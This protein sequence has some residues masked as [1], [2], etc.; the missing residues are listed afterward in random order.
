MNSDIIYV[1]NF[2]IF[3]LGMDFKKTCMT[4]LST[5][6]TPPSGDACTYR[7][8]HNGVD[9]HD[10][11][12][13]D[14]T[15]P[16]MEFMRIIPDILSRNERPP[17]ENE[18]SDDGSYTETGTGIYGND[19]ISCDGSD[20]SE[21][22]SYEDT[23]EAAIQNMDGTFCVPEKQSF[24]IRRMKN[25][26][27]AAQLARAQ[28]RISSSGGSGKSVMRNSFVRS[29]KVYRSQRSAYSSASSASYRPSRLTRRQSVV[30]R[31]SRPTPRTRYNQRNVESVMQ[32]QEQNTKSTSVYNL[33]T[34]AP[35][36]QS[37]ESN[38]NLHH[39]TDIKLVSKSSGY[40]SQ[41]RSP[42]GGVTSPD[43]VDLDNSAAMFQNC[44]FMC[45]FKK[46]K[47]AARVAKTVP[48]HQPAT[49]V[50]MNREAILRKSALL[51][52]T[53][54]RDIEAYLRNQRAT[55]WR[56]ADIYPSDAEW[57]AST[58]FTSDSNISWDPS[59]VSR[60]QRKHHHRNG[61]LEESRVS[62][63]KWDN[64]GLHS[65]TSDVSLNFKRRFRYNSII[66]LTST[67]MV[68]K[69]QGYNV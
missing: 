24:L 11:T 67:P 57:D 61:N 48:H 10:N 62:S 59:L 1:L 47:A 35:V 45:A 55:F 9:H 16:G 42:P 22:E 51:S 17:S 20:V 37:P 26:K 65:Q 14:S 25:A 68:A 54:I 44:N 12:W 8:Y 27:Q 23:T 2:S 18:T 6:Q 43:D 39:V 38:G 49:P 41:G 69:N 19:D 56:N 4:P 30:S 5:Y 53:K 60:P 13:A 50:G 36:V 7:P 66:K 21:D 28:Q 63:V 29:S 34:L 33:G 46:S 15:E 3:F 58:S 32:N 40:A 64:P 52:Q 31:N